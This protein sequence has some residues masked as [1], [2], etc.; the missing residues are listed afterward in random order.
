MCLYKT[1][2]FYRLQNRKFCSKISLLCLGLSVDSI[3]WSTCASFGPSLRFIVIWCWCGL[4]W[5]SLM[6]GWAMWWG[7]AWMIG[8]SAAAALSTGWITYFSTSGC[9][10]C[11]TY[12][13]WASNNSVSLVVC[14]LNAYS[15]CLMQH[16]SWPCKHL[17]FWSGLNT[18]SV[19]SSSFKPSQLARLRPCRKSR[20]LL[21]SAWW[22][23][24][25]C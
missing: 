13:K 3:G 23:C 9:G 17:H 25:S 14:S 8:C 18:S 16:Y 19:A 6:I 21:Y 2:F 7:A 4:N 20:L 24:T 10:S 5:D 1:S 11:L 12:G 22:S 15:Y